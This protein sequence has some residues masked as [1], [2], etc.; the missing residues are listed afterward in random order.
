[1]FD[2]DFCGSPL[3]L[4]NKDRTF[5]IGDDVDTLTEEQLDLCR[6]LDIYI[7]SCSQFSDGFHYFRL[8]FINWFIFSWDL[9]YKKS[10]MLTLIFH[11]KLL[12]LISSLSEVAPV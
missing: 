7:I 2:F 1:M 5:K 8:D 9:V 12:T 3:S 11:L 10:L 4:R 6:I